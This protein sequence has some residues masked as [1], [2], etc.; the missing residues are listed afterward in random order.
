MENKVETHICGPEELPGAMRERALEAL[1]AG[2]LVAV[3][4]ETVYGIAARADRADCLAGLAALKRRDPERAFTWHVGLRSAL[5]P[6]PHLPRLIERLA[7]RYWPGPLTLVLEGSPEAAGSLPQ[8]GWTGVRMPAH[9]VAQAL[10]EAAP[11]PVAMS[12]ANPSG[13]APATDAP[14]AAAVLEQLGVAGGLVL[15]GGPCEL[16][17]SSTVLALGRGRFELLRE[18]LLGL[19]DLR[20][21]AGLRIAFCCTGNTC[22]SPMA[23][24]LA[25]SLV[26][27]ALGIDTSK[28][29]ADFGFHFQSCGVSAMAGT[30]AS[31]NSWEVM[32]QRGLDLSGHSSSPASAQELRD[33]DH[34]YCLTRSH[35]EQLAALLPPD[36][37]TRLQLLD[38]AGEDVPDPFGGPVS[39]YQRC[40]AYIEECLR[41]R[42]A[43]WV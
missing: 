29:P 20:R 6:F 37:G 39:V 31:A 19:D 27:E 14:G 34:V 16:G 12:S 4:T 33:C 11:F 1:S 13:G 28:D 35:L 43:D 23:E 26:A 18:G 36:L 41:A 8:N 5:A 15:D 3:P 10:L 30:P 32:Q 24:A 22:R 7:E 17:E 21:R 42:L 38:P 40:A 25:R 9:P 2:A